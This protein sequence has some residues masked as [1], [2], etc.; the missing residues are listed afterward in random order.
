MSRRKPVVAVCM[1]R[2]NGDI[3][4]AFMEH[5]LALFDHAVILDHRST[6]GTKAYLEAL[7][8][9]LPEKV[10]LYHFVD[11]G[12]YQSEL[13]TWTVRN[14]EICR[15]AQWLFFLDTDE[16]LPFADRQAFDEALSGFSREAVIRMPWK[17]LAPVTYDNS[18]LHDRAYFAGRKAS[19]FC[20]VA[21]QPALV[22]IDD[23]IVLQ[24]N[25]ALQLAGSGKKRKGKRTFPMLHIPIT[26]R[27]QYALKVLLIHLADISKG[28]DSEESF[29]KHRYKRIEPVETNGLSD[30]LLNS[31]ALN[32]GE[33][34]FD[35]EGYDRLDASTEHER[36]ER[37]G[38]ARTELPEID[39]PFDDFA[40]SIVKLVAQH[41]QH[42]QPAFMAGGDWDF[43]LDGRHIRIEAASSGSSPTT[44]RR[45]WLQRLRGKE[46]G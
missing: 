13:M 33:K 31:S 35:I 25:H 18:N 8:E 38:V 34:Q 3:I 6:D 28:A 19:D 39:V 27:E 10:S 14:L 30:A 15:Q 12:F 26:S 1:A 22:D 11:E 45:S 5:L 21:F 17:N 36:L 44:A 9:A 29:R 40:T 23:T 16:F 4:Q 43:M 37:L 32:Y 41:L 46:S 7:A 24:G 20:K 2:N 42:A